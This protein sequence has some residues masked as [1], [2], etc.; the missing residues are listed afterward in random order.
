MR[1]F[2]TRCTVP[3]RTGRHVIYA[4]WGRTPPTFER[5][6]GCID[7]QFSGTPPPTVTA[8][9]VLNPNVTTFTGSG[10]IALNGSSSVGSNLDL[11]LERGFAQNPALYTI[12]NPM[13]AQATLNLGVPHGVGQRHGESAR[14]QRQRVGYRDR[15]RSCTS[16]P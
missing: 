3:S 10:S 11:Y 16:R 1:I 4:E 14:D 5:F 8:N 9:I 15:A 6:H 12:T 2:T 13:S 7:A